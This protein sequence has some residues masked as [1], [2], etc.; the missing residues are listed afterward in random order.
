VGVLDGLDAEGDRSLWVPAVDG[1]ERLGA[2]HYV[3]PAGEDVDIEA[4]KGFTGLVAELVISKSAYGDYF[5]MARR[6]QPLT[7]ASEL[8]WQLLPPLTFGTE[9]LVISA[10]FLPTADL[11]GDAF[12]YGVDHHQA[13]VAIFDAVGHG[14][15]AGLI[16]TAAIAAYRNSRREELKLPDSAARIGSVIA[17]HCGDSAFATGVLLSLDLASGRLS[18]CVA[19][20]PRPLVVRRGR[21]VKTLEAESGMPFGLGPVSAVHEEQLEPG[22]QLLL[23]TDGVTDARD[24]SGNPFEIDRLID[25]VSQT[26]GDDPVPERMRALMH[27]V[28]AHSDGPLRDDATV[29]MIEWRGPGIPT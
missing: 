26:A 1:T 9:D 15:G 29:V 27:A 17:E 13:Q 28:D 23:Y 4:V 5:W 3:F 8:L 24:A 10:V 19:G 2:V 25:L 14:L 21:V 7:V 22:D 20:H 6:R 11:G 16:A 18:W 12:D